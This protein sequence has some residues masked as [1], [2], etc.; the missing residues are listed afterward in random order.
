[1][2]VMDYELHDRTGVELTRKIIMVP[3]DP[4]VGELM[5]YKGKVLSKMW[6]MEPSLFGLMQAWTFCSFSLLSCFVS[7]NA[8]ISVG[9]EHYEIIHM[10]MRT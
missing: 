2:P 6:T 5:R 7:H 1:M 3:T 10:A 8:N 4:R 9:A